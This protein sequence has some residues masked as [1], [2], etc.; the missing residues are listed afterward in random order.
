M[1]RLYGHEMRSASRVHAEREFAGHLY[2]SP[3]VNAPNLRVSDAERNRVIEELQRHTADGRL[4]L[5]EFEA[6]VE[7]TLRARTAAELRVVLSQP[8]APAY[9]R[10]RQTPNT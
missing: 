2:D 1:C 4:T 5:D 7:E 6:R 10:N 8:P 3:T 9:E